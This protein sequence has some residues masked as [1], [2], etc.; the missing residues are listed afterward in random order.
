MMTIF[1]FSFNNTGRGLNRHRDINVII[2][3][4]L[5]KIAVNKQNIWILFK[6][7]KSGFNFFFNELKKRGIQLSTPLN[8]LLV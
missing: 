1:Y 7:Q 4:I 6:Q 3:K 2:C 5:F 8:T